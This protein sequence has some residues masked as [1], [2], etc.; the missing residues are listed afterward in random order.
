LI[1]ATDSDSLTEVVN[2]FFRKRRMATTSGLVLAKISNPL[3]QH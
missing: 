3:F 2:M 1:L